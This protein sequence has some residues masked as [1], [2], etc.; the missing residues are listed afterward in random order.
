[1]S[2]FEALYNQVVNEMH[3]DNWKETSWQDTTED[4]KVIKV[5]INDLF[6]FSK[7][8]P[9]VELNVKDL[10]SLALH[11]TKIDP[12]TLANIQKANLEYPILVLD[13]S[14][15]KGGRPEASTIVQHPGLASILDGHHRLQKAIVN[16]I[17]KIKAK[18]L[19]LSEMPEDWQWVFRP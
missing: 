12:E 9:V 6:A 13:K 18:M 10:E 7:D 19:H 15:N 16:K 4:G 11:K 5:T 2:K 8:I 14:K 17:P 3:G 1:M